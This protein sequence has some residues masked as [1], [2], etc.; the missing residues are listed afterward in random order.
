MASSFPR[1][2]VTYYLDGQELQQ[3]QGEPPRL[4]IGPVTTT[5]VISMTACTVFMTEVSD[6]AGDLPGDLAPHY[7]RGS[8]P[9]G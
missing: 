9:N 7:F 2:P 6:E 8:A 3:D 1:W 4:V 5:T